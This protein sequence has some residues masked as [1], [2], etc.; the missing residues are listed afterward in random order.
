M[1]LLEAVE[2]HFGVAIG[3][4]QTGVREPFKLSP[5]EYLFHSEGWDIPSWW[6]GFG[7]KPVVRAFTVGEL[8][9]ILQTL[10]AN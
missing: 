3:N 7:Q 1:E 9:S 4:N 5:N 6:F 10:L 2:N 8:Y